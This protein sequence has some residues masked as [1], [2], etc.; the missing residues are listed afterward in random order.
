MRREKGDPSMVRAC[1][2]QEQAM[3]LSRSRCC[4]SRRRSPSM[5]AE[6]MGCVPWHAKQRKQAH[7][8]PLRPGVPPLKRSRAWLQVAA[9]A[10]GDRG[11]RAR[12]A[13]AGAGPG[14]RADAGR[15]AGAGGG[16]EAARAHGPA[17]GPGHSRAAPAAAHR[18]A[19]CSPPRGSDHLLSDTI[20]SLCGWV[21]CMRLSTLK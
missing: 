2:R 6:C 5:Q 20:S 21:T 17:E 13:G 16:S 1:T 11:G 19:A 8:L 10:R 18:C 15:A 7:V 12:A 14:G 9:G 3:G 4:H